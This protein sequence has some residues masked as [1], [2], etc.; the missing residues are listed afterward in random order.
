MFVALAA[1]ANMMLEPLTGWTLQSLLDLLFRPLAWLMGIPGEH[2][3]TVG[4]SL[5]L[6]GRSRLILTYALCG[7]S[8]LGS[9]GSCWAG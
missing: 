1:L 7:F 5:G 3:A 8:N 9:V 2:L 4:S 6:D